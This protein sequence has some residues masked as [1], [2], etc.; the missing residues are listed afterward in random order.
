[1]A[2][3]QQVSKCARPEKSIA[4]SRH[5]TQLQK[6]PSHIPNHRR[7]QG[8]QE[9][10]IYQAYCKVKESKNMIKALFPGRW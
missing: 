4:S 1:M 8:S 6:H 10:Q 7:N 5:E 3:R 9:T 2:Q